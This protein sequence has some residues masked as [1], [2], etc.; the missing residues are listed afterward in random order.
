MV[1][2]R[3]VISLR[4]RMLFEWRIRK[5]IELETLFHKPNILEM[6]RNK[7]LQWTEHAWSNLS[8]VI[9]IVLEENLTGK[10]H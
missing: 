8:P 7:R 2:N 10:N 3:P 6:I 1:L 4:R 9:R 5:N